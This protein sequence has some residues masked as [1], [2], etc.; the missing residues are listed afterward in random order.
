MGEAAAGKTVRPFPRLLMNEDAR[1]Y[2]EAIGL[3]LETIGESSVAALKTSDL[4]HPL[5]YT[6]TP[7]GPFNTNGTVPYLGS[8]GEDSD[9]QRDLAALLRALQEP[10]AAEV[11]DFDLLRLR[12]QE[13]GAAS[14]PKDLSNLRKAAKLRSPDLQPSSL[15]SL[16]VEQ[17]K[18]WQK[19][20]QD[21]A[22]ILA[23]DLTDKSWAAVETLKPLGQAAATG[24][25]QAV[26]A[27]GEVVSKVASEVPNV[28]FKTASVV[29]RLPSNAMEIQ[30]LDPLAVDLQLHLTAIRL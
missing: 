2:Y 21:A 10:T 22:T 25:A 19:Q 18:E 24:A 17:V 5:I 26:G 11:A 29:S 6:K 7:L 23:D 16:M 13:H 1:D 4:S 27:V 30:I 28:I 3:G 14:T 12:Y 9:S 8:P 20:A 15:P